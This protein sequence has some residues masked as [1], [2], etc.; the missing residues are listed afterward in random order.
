MFYTVYIT[1][2]FDSK[3]TRSIHVFQI[4]QEFCRVIK[5]ENAVHDIRERF[6]KYSGAVTKYCK[7]QSR[8]PAFIKN[9]L[10][11]LQELSHCEG[12]STS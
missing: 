10:C 9:M 4:R 8:K 7:E 6:L 3:I 12:R 11:F 1:K 5:D 2:K